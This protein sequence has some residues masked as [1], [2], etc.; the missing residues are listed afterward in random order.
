MDKRI[1]T[2]SE[3]AVFFRAAD[4]YG[5][6][7]NM[8]NKFPLVVNAIKIPSSESLYQAMR[9]P[10]NPDIQ[11]R[12]IQQ[13]NGF[14]AKQESQLFTPETRADWFDVNVRIMEWTCAVKLMQHWETI[15][16]VM[17]EIGVDK[18]IVEKS[19]HDDFWG[20]MPQ[21]DGTLVG[22]N[23]LGRIW[24]KHYR[25]VVSEGRSAFTVLE[26]LDIPNFKLM[27]ELI[28]PI[29]MEGV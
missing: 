11:R 22:M 8:A 12:I 21:S 28:L 23:Y 10:H 5:C 18:P 4:K 3:C 26:P 1:Y 2:P 7:Q 13:G 24:R 14:S 17:S 29:K 16:E 25:K 19:R 6:F 15:V 9:Y 20:A 27:G